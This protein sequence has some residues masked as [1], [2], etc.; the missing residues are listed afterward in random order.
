MDF[1]QDLSASLRERL[2][3]DS[4]DSAF[5]WIHPDI[6]SPTYTSPSHSDSRHR[7]SCI[8]DVARR[9]NYI[10]VRLLTIAVRT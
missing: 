5:I 8:V 9:R 1:V 2:H 10:C 3:V 6:C 4:E 7:D